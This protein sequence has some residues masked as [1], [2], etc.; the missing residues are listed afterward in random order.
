M[1]ELMSSLVTRIIRLY[2]IAELLSIPVIVTG[3]VLFVLQRRFPI[4]RPFKGS[5]ATSAAWTLLI[6]PL[7][8]TF[9]ALE[10]AALT[11]L[12]Q[13]PLA[14]GG[15]DTIQNWP[16]AI[17]V[18]IGLLVVDFVDFSSHRLRHRIPLLWRFH[19]I[20][21]S[22]PHMSFWASL[23]SHPVDVIIGGTLLAI[24]FLI[25]RESAMVFGLV[26]AIRTVLFYFH[27]SN[28][29]VRLGR[30]DSVFVTPQWHRI[31]HST[32]HEHYDTNFGATLTIWD[33]L[34]RTALVPGPDDFPPVG[35]G[36]ELC[37]PDAENIT[38]VPQA[39]F[40]QVIFP[41]LR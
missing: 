28:V 41:F 31:H 20:H 40:R 21:H 26:F 24:P 37:P 4:V 22:A 27:H 5:S 2:E 17:R 35:L 30:L 29:R 14:W 34:F 12:F 1:P 36:P 25:V 18:V 9:V 10:F 16:I 13:G 8:A 7:S 3:I 23:R 39:L 6:A 38:G 19:T 32:L 15:F 33:R 11:S